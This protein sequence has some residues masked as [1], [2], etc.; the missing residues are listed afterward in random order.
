MT[1]AFALTGAALVALAAPAAA[2]DAKPA[3]VADLVKAVDIPFEQF[4]LPNGL[5]VVVHTDRKAPIVAVSVW[6][7]IGSKDEP[8]GRTGFAHLF[9]HLMFGGS[10][11][12]DQSWFQPMQAIGATG[13]NGTTYFDRTNYFETVPRGALDTALFLESDRMG[14]LLGAITQAKLD[15]QRGV[16]QNEKRGNDNQPGGLVDYKVLE[17]LFP[18]GH[19]YHHTTIGS[20]GDLDKASLAD[21]KGWFQQHYGP[22]NAVLVLAGDIDIA[23]AKPL[24]AKYFG[25]IPRG[26]ANVPTQAAVPTLAKRVDLVFKD[27]VAQTTVTRV[28]AIPGSL[29]PVAPALDMVASI[30]GG[31]DSSRLQQSLV[32]GSKVA[33]SVSAGSDNFERVGEFEIDAVV[34]P[35]ADPVAVGAAIDAAVADFIRSGPTEAELR[36]AKTSSIAGTI[37]GLE[38]VGGFSGKAVTLASGA[39]YAGDPGF[40]RKELAEEA[41]LTPAAVQAAAR[42][43]LSRPV[44]AYTLEPGQRDAY[45]EAAS[46]TAATPAARPPV[47]APAGA[48]GPAPQTATRGSIPLPAPIADLD[49]PRI[50]HAVLSN[51]IPVEFAR[52]GAVPVV[53]VSIDFDA[54]AAADPKAKP[55][56]HSLMLRVL[57]Q[58]TDRYDTAQ[59]AA[60]QEA[61]G[62]A[63][64]TS[65]TMDRS[66]VSMAALTPNLAASLDLMADIVRHPAFRP[67]DIDRV[68]GQQLAGIAAETKEPEPLALRVLPPMLYGKNSPYGVPFTGTGDP[69]VVAALTRADLVAFRDAWLRPDKATIFVVGDTSLAAVVPLLEKS[70]GG[71]HVSGTGPT[72]DFTGALPPVKGRIV[73]IDRP[74]VPQSLIFAGQLTPK[75]GTDDLVPLTQA[76]AVLGG[77]FSSRL[78]TDIRETKHWSYGVQGFLNTVQHIVPYM[79][80]AP[81]QADQTGPSI[82]AMR[83]DIASFLG[84][85]GVT[86]AELKRTIDGAVRALPGR[87]ETAGAVLS[88][89][90]GNQVYGRPDDYQATLPARYRALTAPVLDAA[91]KAAIDPDR[92]TWV[93]IGD[94]AKVKP[95]LDTLGLPVEVAAAPDQ[96]TK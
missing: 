63:I 23:A 30:I 72:K 73:V 48:T 10:E 15:I 64:N 21:V 85:K 39:V 45:D 79:I 80:Y 92:I 29:D 35:G 16:V 74:G 3:P 89:M 31:L 17:T 13:L 67:A 9:E 66:S 96:G 27:Q 54:G 32:R 38:G 25:D 71:W 60:T 91:A 44:L 47:K 86:P 81:V 61:L 65:A 78:N 8:A 95:Q 12:S 57:K 11:N 14:H 50:E 2:Q 49:F 62:T 75:Q 59:I 28:W 40:Y 70:F 36:R 52:R 68:R 7:H 46:V 6:Y 37:R 4:T 87:F 1:K 51:G 19:P 55:G 82:A 88:A 34:K 18:E 76:N 42:T 93:V 53:N 69:A 90:E 22:N 43:W 58:G 41:A 84:D 77:S 33:V 83:G 5:R 56:T 26:P 94:A 20:M 24:V